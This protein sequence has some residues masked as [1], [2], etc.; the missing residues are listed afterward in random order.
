LTKYSLGNI[1]FAQSLCFFQ[2]RS[3]TEDLK[4]ECSTGTLSQLRYAGVVSSETNATLQKSS[5]DDEDVVVGNDFCGN[6][7]LLK[8]E[9]DCRES[10]DMDGLNNEYDKEC[11]DKEECKI[12]LAAFAKKDGVF[13]EKCTDRFTQIYIQASCVPR[14][15]AVTHAQ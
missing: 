10:V 7:E 15:E 4:L 2:F 1:G 8:D 6:P 9:T 11:K 3:I 5:E 13:P 14:P 12:N